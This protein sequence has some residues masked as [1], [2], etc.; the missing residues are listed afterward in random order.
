MSQPDHL[1]HVRALPPEVQP[2]VS[3]WIAQG[4][5]HEMIHGVLNFFTGH[6]EALIHKLT[7]EARIE[8]LKAFD[9][10]QRIHDDCPLPLTCVG[11]GN[12]ESDFDN[13]KE[14]RL[15]KLQSQVDNKEEA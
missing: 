11:Y 4:R 14:I 12:A 3:E 15:N 6:G 10:L 2:A 1:K 7:N 9:P 5:S 13:E 8:E